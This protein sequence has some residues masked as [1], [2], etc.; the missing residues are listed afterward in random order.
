MGLIEVGRG[1]LH[2]EG[3]CRWIIQIPVLR[4]EQHVTA[5]SLRAVKN[6]LDLSNG[7]LLDVVDALV[8]D[9]HPTAAVLSLWYYSL[10]GEVL[11]GMILGVH[12]E[13]VLVGG[14]GETL[15]EGPGDENTVTFET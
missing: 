12:R 7:P 8:P 9:G 6:E 15:G 3:P 11:E 2:V 4:L 1:S 10:E 14:L 13:M 5:R